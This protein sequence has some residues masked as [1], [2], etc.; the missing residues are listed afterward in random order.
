MKILFLGLVINSVNMMLALPQKIV[1]NIQNKCLQR[2]VLPKT[3]IVELDRLLGKSS[4]TPQTMLPGRIAT[5]TNSRGEGNK[6][7][8]NQNK[9]KPIVTGKVEVMEGEFTYWERH[10]TENRNAVNHPNGCFQHKL[11]G[12]LS[13]KHYG[14]NLVISEKDKTYQCT[15]AHCSETCYISLYRRKSVTAIH[16]QILQLCL[17]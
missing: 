6:F 16:L 2:I 13:G 9:I 14:G 11:G 10:T 12:S 7:L 17:T 5:T 15:G 3:T 8:S 4:F 1:L